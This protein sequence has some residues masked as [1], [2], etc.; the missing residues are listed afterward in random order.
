MKRDKSSYLLDG[1]FTFENYR[2]MSM[3]QAYYALCYP[4]DSKSKCQCKCMKECANASQRFKEKYGCSVFCKCSAN[5]V[6]KFKKKL[7]VI[8]TQQ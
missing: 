3:Q 8:I 5:Y 2:K 1:T 6:N 4:Q 7:Q